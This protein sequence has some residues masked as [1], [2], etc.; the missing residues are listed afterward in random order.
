MSFDRQKELADMDVPWLLRHGWTVESNLCFRHILHEY[1]LLGKVPQ[2]ERI[3]QL[4]LQ[5]NAVASTSKIKD[6][7]TEWFQVVGEF[8]NV[9][10][11]PT[12]TDNGVSNG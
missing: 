4:L 1:N 5:Y 6:S 7:L 12:D 9:I 3:E 8:R 11:S 2:L 10:N